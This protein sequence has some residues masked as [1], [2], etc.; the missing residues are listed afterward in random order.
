[1]GEWEGL[2]WN[3]CSCEIINVSSGHELTGRGLG[4][5][6]AIRG[7]LR[8]G[9]RVRLHDD[10]INTALRAWNLTILQSTPS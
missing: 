6:S 4:L 1:M 8:I 5:I 10:S 3:T 2:W 7:T 9:G